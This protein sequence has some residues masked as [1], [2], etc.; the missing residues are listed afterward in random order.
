MW[1]IKERRPGH[2]VNRRNVGCCF[3][4]DGEIHNCHWLLILESVQLVDPE[5]AGQYRPAHR[6][7]V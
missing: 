7:K 5:A 1:G 4:A 3:C 6:R 2:G